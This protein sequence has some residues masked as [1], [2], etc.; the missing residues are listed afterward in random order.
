MAG[1]GKQK[2]NVFEK[3]E[4]EKIGVHVVRLACG[5]VRVSIPDETG[6]Y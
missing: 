1:R 6:G 2:Y 3:A 4:C 5:T